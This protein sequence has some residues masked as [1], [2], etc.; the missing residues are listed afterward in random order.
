MANQMIMSTV[1][2]GVF[3]NVKERANQSTYL[4]KNSLALVTGLFLGFA[5]ACISIPT[6]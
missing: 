4:D 3:N 2:F 5:T 6:D 1:M